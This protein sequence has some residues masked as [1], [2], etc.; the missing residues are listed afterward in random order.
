M[1]ITIKMKIKKYLQKLQKNINKNGINK[2]S[3]VS[4]RKY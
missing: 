1:K 2:I 4:Y 3:T